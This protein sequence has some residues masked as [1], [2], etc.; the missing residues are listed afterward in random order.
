M[1]GRVVTNGRPDT[2]P[3]GNGIR[4]A[5]AHCGGEIGVRIEG[6][7]PENRPLPGMGDPRLPIYWL[8]IRPTLCR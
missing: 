5:R 1:L 8:P 4:L 2:G 6:V 7:A 3:N